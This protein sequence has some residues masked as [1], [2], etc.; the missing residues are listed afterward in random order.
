MASIMK[1]DDRIRLEILRALSQK[2]SLKA[3]LKQLKK[4]TKL[5]AATLKSS[6]EFL[7]KEGVLKGFG[8]KIDFRKFNLKLEATTLL[9]ANLARKDLATEFFEL[10]EK[11]PHTYWFSS[12]L[13]AGNYNLIQRQLFADVESYQKNL[14]KHYIEKMS[15]YF[16][17]I[18]DKQVFF[19]TE[20]VYKA[21]SRTEALIKIILG[22]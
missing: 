20:P 12:V 6:I 11:D 21:E 18:K 15:D 3:H 16:S 19:T 5:H 17:F 10:V 9:Q 1:I 4:N 22:E 14:Q 7:K 8:P 2:N 13:S